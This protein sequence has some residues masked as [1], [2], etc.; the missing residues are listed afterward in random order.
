MNYVCANSPIEA[1]KQLKLSFWPQ[2]DIPQLLYTCWSLCV[3]HPALG[4]KAEAMNLWHSMSCFCLKRGSIFLHL[5]C[6]QFFL[7]FRAWCDQI[8][9]YFFSEKCDAIVF[10]TFCL[11]LDSNQCLIERLWRSRWEKI[12]IN[13]TQNDIFFD[14]FCQFC[15]RLRD[16][17]HRVKIN[18]FEQQ[19]DPSIKQP[20]KWCKILVYRK[21]M[22]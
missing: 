17:R 20:E 10:I 14:N 1:E 2:V 22:K 13:F 15:F 21:D 4:R 16:L 3:L 18:K 5:R 11:V 19:L 6:V 8:Y 7:F 12:L 9:Q